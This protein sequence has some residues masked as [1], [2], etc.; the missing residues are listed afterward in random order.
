VQQLQKLVASRD[1]IAQTGRK[2]R[3]DDVSHQFVDG[4]SDDDLAPVDGN[5]R[6]VDEI[7]SGRV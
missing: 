1:R 6:E 4:R 7:E 3:S 5:E 2:T